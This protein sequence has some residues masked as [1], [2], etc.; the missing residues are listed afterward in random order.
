MTVLMRV[1]WTWEPSVLLGMAVWTAAY[2]TLMGPLRGRRRLGSAPSAVRQAAFHF[3]TLVATFA[4]I[5]PL[6]TLGDEYLFSAHMVQH[7]LLIYV[8]AP[9]WL[10]GIPAW[11]PDRLLPKWAKWLARGVTRPI[12]AFT[13]LAGVIL[14]WHTPVLYGLAQEYEGVHIAE[15]LMYMGAGLIGWWPLAG[16]DG[17]NALPRPSAPVRMLYVLGMVLPCTLLGALLTFAQS[18]LYRFYL[19]APHPFGLNALEDQRLGGL[20]M[21]VPT[22]MLLLLCLTIIGANWFSERGAAEVASERSTV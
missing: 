4:L 11:L 20:L 21:W 17:S 19:E 3:G 22:H 12:A 5:S 15:H 14:T 18:P 13:I 16:P 1:G 7:L 6:D 2:M 9:C 10:F 8:A